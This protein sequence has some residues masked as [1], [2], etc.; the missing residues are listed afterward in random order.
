MTTPMASIDG[1]P[2]WPDKLAAACQFISTQILTKAITAVRKAKTAVRT[3]NTFGLTERGRKAPAF[4]R[5]DIRPPS[6]KRSWELGDG[7][8]GDFPTP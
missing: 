8:W 6:S 2:A 7:L 3:A 1:A 5:G 4:R